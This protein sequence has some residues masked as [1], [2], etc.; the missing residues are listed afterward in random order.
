M[1]PMTEMYFLWSVE[2]VGV[3][4][5]MARFGGIDW[6]RR[7]ASVLIKTQRPEG[8]WQTNRGPLPDTSFAL[9]FLRRS[10][11]T[12]GMPQ[13]VT[14]RSSESGENR[15]RAGKLDDLIRTV[16]PPADP[17]NEPTRDRP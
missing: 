4:L 9:L 1:T 13:L 6:Y 15:M 14:G 7:G 17:D 16:R 8:V 12:S 3:A 10:N 11:L 5:G 2:R